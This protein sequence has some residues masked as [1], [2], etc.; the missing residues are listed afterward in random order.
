M[1]KVPKVQRLTPRLLKKI[2]S[3]RTEARGDLSAQ[4]Q[5]T[6][7]ISPEVMASAAAANGPGPL[8]TSVSAAAAANAGV[9]MPAPTNVAADEQHLAAANDFHNSS[10]EHPLQRTVVVNIR[11]S[12]SDLCLRKAKATW[13]PPSADATKSIFQQKKFVDLM[14]TAESQGDLKVRA[15][16]PF[17]RPCFC[18]NAHVFFCAH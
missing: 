17:H 18:S 3:I 1:K 13:T 12:L 10:P 14:G 11:A 9:V 8:A 15:R 16:P 7:A 4:M 5:Q 6:L 2:M